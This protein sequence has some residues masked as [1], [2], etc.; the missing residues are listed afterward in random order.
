MFEPRMAEIDIE[1]TPPSLPNAELAIKKIQRRNAKIAASVLLRD[2]VGR[3]HRSQRIEKQ[4]KLSERITRAK[5]FLD[6]WNAWKS[7]FDEFARTFVPSCSATMTLIETIME[8]ADENGIDLD[9][10]LGCGFLAWRGKTP[11]LGVLAANALRYHAEYADKVMTE[12]EDANGAVR[13]LSEEN[14]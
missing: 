2:M 13:A 1:R 7:H 4:W 8:I 10:L 12:I 9:I 3:D 11:A 14:F 6:S 5:P